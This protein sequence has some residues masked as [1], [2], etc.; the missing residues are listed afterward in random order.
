[1]IQCVGSLKECN[2][3]PYVAVGWWEVGGERYKAAAPL[4]T[5]STIFVD[6]GGAAMEGEASIQTANHVDDLDNVRLALR[7]DE[8]IAQ[9]EDKEI[10]ACDLQN[11]MEQLSCL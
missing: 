5:F 2:E 4:A 10:Q 7:L 8:I 11:H 1:M 9:C 6:G 3:C